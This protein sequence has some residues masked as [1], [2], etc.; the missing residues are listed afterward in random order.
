MN[1]SAVQLLRTQQSAI[2]GDGA[3]YKIKIGVL[4]ARVL[5]HKNT[6]RKGLTKEHMGFVKAMSGTN[7]KIFFNKQTEFIPCSDVEKIAAR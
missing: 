1:D 5:C 2:A 7:G 3:S 6:G 4:F